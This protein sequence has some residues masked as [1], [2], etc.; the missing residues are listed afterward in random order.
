MCYL[1]CATKFCLPAECAILEHGMASTDPEREKA[2]RDYER[3]IDPAEA[4]VAAQFRRAATPILDRP[5]LLL[6]EFQ[7]YR[8][9]IE[10][11]AIRRA[12]VSEREAL[13]SLL[14][15]Y[16]KKLEASVDRV[17]SGQNG[18]DSDDDEDRF[19]FDHGRGGSGQSRA[20]LLSSRLVGIVFLRQMCA[21]VTSVLATSQGILNDLDGYPRFAQQCQ[22]LISRIKGEEG[23]RFEGWLSDVQQKIDDEDMSLKL[24]GS[25]MCWKDGVLVVNFSENLVRF[26]R[27][28]HQLNEMGFDIPRMGKKKGIMEKAQEAEKYYRYGIL[29]KKTAN[30][31]NSISEQMIDVQEQLLLESLNAFASVVS[32]P[33]LTRSDG[34]ISWSNPAECENYIRMLQE[35]AEKLS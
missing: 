9:L 6:Q 17:E 27:E 34:D 32:R 14:R 33:S 4:A 1:I 5:Q 10:S 20:K 2:V 29:L 22:S 8:N 12:L 13:L 35:A 31:Y 25:L 21:R 30:F 24:Q 18:I 19:R 11:P 15:D 28:V 7:K 3:A 16:L 26:L 23:S